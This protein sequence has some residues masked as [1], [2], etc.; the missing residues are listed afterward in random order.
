M[1]TRDGNQISSASQISAKLAIPKA[2]VKQTPPKAT[3]PTPQRGCKMTNNSTEQKI[4]IAV[5][6]AP[7]KIVS[8]PYNLFE[9][10]I[11]L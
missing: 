8:H 11:A 2:R 10:F 7:M 1:V 5:T 4:A 9:H 3:Q 6:N